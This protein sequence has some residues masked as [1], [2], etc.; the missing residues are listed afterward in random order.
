MAIEPAA[1]SASPAV[2]TTAVVARGDS[3]QPGRQC[4]RNGQSV[5]HADHD[6]ADELAGGKV[7]FDV[8]DLVHRVVVPGDRRGGAWFAVRVGSIG[9]ATGSPRVALEPVVEIVMP[10]LPPCQETGQQVGRDKRDPP[11]LDLADVGLLVFPAKRQRTRGRG[12]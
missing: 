5:G 4:E 6:V 11:A 12:R 7:A 8:G 3:R 9:F 1:I 2:T 10:A